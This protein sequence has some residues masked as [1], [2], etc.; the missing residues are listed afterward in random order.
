MTMGATGFLN[1]QS[2]PGG[3]TLV[4]AHSGFNDLIRLAVLWTVRHHWMVEARFTFN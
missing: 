1:R 3:T 4:D 2:Q